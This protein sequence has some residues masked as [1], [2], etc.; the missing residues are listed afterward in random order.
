V[1]QTASIGRFKKT[2]FT[3]GRNELVP[4][5]NSFTYSANVLFAFP[6]MLYISRLPCILSH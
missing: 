4:C 6:E 1:T 5:V 3:L 2:C